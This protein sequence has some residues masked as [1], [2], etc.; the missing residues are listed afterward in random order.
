MQRNVNLGLYCSDKSD[1]IYLLESSFI[2]D[3]SALKN[4]NLFVAPFAHKA[5][6]K[7]IEV[8]INEKFNILIP[9]LKNEIESQTGIIR[10][11]SF[12][13]V[14]VAHWLSTLVTII[15]IYDR[16]L[17]LFTQENRHK[18]NVE[19]LKIQM[20]FSFNGTHDFLYGAVFSHDFNHWL[21]SR[22]I[23]WKYKD[24]FEIKYIEKDINVCN[25]FSH[26]ATLRSRLSLFLDELLIIKGSF[27]FSKFQKLLITLENLLRF[28]KPFPIA[29]DNKSAQLINDDIDWNFLFKYLM[30]NNFKDQQVLKSKFLFN[31]RKY[32]IICSTLFYGEDYFKAKIANYVSSG[33]QCYPVQ[34]G[35]NYGSLWAH[36]NVNLNEYNHFGYISWG[37]KNHQTYS[38]QAIP[39]PSIKSSKLRELKS[40]TNQTTQRSFIIVGQDQIPFQYTLMSACEPCKLPLYIETKLRLFSLLDSSKIS[41]EY[42]QA[43]P[44]NLSFND[45]EEVVKSHPNIKFVDGDLNTRLVQAKA[46]ILDSPGTTFY[47]CLAAGIITFGVWDEESWL[48]DNDSHELFELLKKNKIL[49][50]S[51]ESLV[52]FLDEN[53]LD[54]WWTNETL[55]SAIK[56]W[57]DFHARTS[58]DWYSEWRKIIK[59]LD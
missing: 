21:L 57:C 19:L 53:D 17:K 10:P 2:K 52:K 30:P 18:L 43:P 32:L 15:S 1:D 44:H 24:H 11:I 36:S 49:H 9:N 51:P 34:H 40:K 13:R 38:R 7:Q 12:Y 37:W 48:F 58:N 5:E 46:V 22:L 33:G 47:H 56:L 45:R 39:A 28:K 4:S 6:W 42:R 20:P 55:Q 25:K 59:N 14:F 35:C 31:N 27:G 16:K 29:I 3:S 23:E 41:Y 50:T 26:R 54:S 8:E